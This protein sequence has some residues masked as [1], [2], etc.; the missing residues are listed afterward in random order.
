[1]NSLPSWM[2]PQTTADDWQIPL[3]AGKRRRG[4]AGVVRRSA[5]ALAGILARTL[6]DESCASRAGFLQS[7]D[8]R[9][10]IAGL[11]VLLVTATLVHSITALAVCYG[12][13]AL[14]AVLSR[15]PAGRFLGVWLTVPLFSAAIMLPATLNV[16][17]P[18]N[19]LVTIAHFHEGRFLGW[20]VPSVLSVTDAGLLAAGRMILRTAVCVSLAALLASTTTRARLFRGLRALG[21]PRLF[22]TLLGMMDRYL[23][24]LIRAAEE[25]HLARIS[26]SISHTNLRREHAWAAAGI[27]SVFRRSYSLSQSVYL[28]MLSRGYT[29]EVK[30]LDDPP[31]HARDWAF[32][33]AAIALAALLLVIG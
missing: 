3:A 1:M 22:V 8:A 29:G 13:C 5:S 14:L 33:A 24:L 30:L 21:A 18:G 28:A 17:T 11:L 12:A 19:P 32:L 7:V 4:R 2:L 9:L 23:A 16:V 20:H 26:R 10:K 15:L 27:A 25:V 6:A 31:A